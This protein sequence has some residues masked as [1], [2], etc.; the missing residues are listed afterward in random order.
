MVMTTAALFVALALVAP[1]PGPMQRAG[2]ALDRAA[3]RVGQTLE[4]AL[5]E[6]RVKVAL[7]E[8]LKKEA[9][10][11]EVEASAG[12]VTL[13]GV[14]AS[15]AG[16]ALAEQVARSVS[17]VTR[18]VNQVQVA[19]TPSKNP[20]GRAAQKVEQEAADALLEAKIKARLLEVMG[21][22]AFQVEVEATDGVVSLSGTVRRKEHKA[23]A[24]TTAKATPGVVAV[25]NL[26]RV[27]E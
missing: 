15:R 6:A 13:S 10:H 7:F 9:L 25:H 4:D 3:S 19:E 23:L 17:G 18:V 24:A 22:A 26:L 12:T 14:V 1:T 5:L 2:Q 20:V 27:A 11:V 8:H 16:Q 21:L